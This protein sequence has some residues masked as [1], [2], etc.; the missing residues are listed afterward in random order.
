M[1]KLL[2]LSCQEAQGLPDLPA[3]LGG[4]SVKR[5]EKSLGSASDQKAESKLSSQIG[6]GMVK[7]RGGFEKAADSDAQQRAR[8][9]DQSLAETVNVAAISL[10]ETTQEQ[11]LGGAV[12][13]STEFVP[14]KSVNL[15]KNRAGRQHKGVTREE[16]L[17]RQSEV[18]KACKVCIFL[19]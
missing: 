18:V 13:T 4:G 6:T 10:L 15:K 2:S 3:E 5:D 11:S 14:Y 19:V 1:L 12:N 17:R 16:W 9:R 8:E 7:S